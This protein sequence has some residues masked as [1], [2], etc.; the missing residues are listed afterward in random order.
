MTTTSTTSPLNDNDNRN[1]EDEDKF[2]QVFCDLGFGQQDKDDDEQE[3]LQRALKEQGLWKSSSGGGSRVLQTICR[4]FY[5]MQ[6]PNQLARMLQDDFNL[7]PLQAHMVRAVL[8]RMYS[9]QQENDNVTQQS[10][11]S[12]NQ[13]ASSTQFPAAVATAQSTSVAPS[14]NAAVVG[15]PATTIDTS[16]NVA[17]PLYKQVKVRAVTTNRTE[18]GF[19]SS[20][21]DNPALA[22]LR[23]EMDQFWHEFMT[24]PNPY[25]P[26]AVPLRNATAE[27]YVRHANLFLGWYLQQ[28]HFDDD[29]NNQTTSP[30]SL[31]TIFPDDSVESVSILLD[32]VRWLREDR[33]ISASYEANVWRGLTKL[34][35]FRHSQLQGQPAA[36][37]ENLPA[38]VQ[39]RKW[40]REAHG[41]SKNAPRRS[42]EDRKWLS[43]D[44]MDWVSS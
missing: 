16:K 38:L 5:N 19:S 8:W 17:R 3:K 20:D 14:S 40:H 15:N 44:D 37:L 1:E 28:Q 31:C 36:V 25:H 24:R 39:I 26:T 22:T 18:Y 35:Q 4:D 23:Q 7:P 10:S 2:F 29:S 42:Q 30:M 21:N 32:F 9:Q 11:V 12:T 34:V 33:Q 41:A 43:W 6:Q 27:V 13:M